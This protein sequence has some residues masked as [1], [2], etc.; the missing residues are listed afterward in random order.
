MK[1]E[2]VVKGLR[3]FDQKHDPFVDLELLDFGEAYKFLKK[4]F[5]EK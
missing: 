5:A 2:S 3:I 4:H 1:R